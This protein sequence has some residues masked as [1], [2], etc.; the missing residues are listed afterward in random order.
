MCAGI[1]PVHSTST[2]AGAITVVMLNSAPFGAQ[3]AILAV[4]LVKL[5]LERAAGEYRILGYQAD[6]IVVNEQAY[7]QAIVVSPELAPEV[8]PVNSVTDMDTAHFE[9]LLARK[10]EVVL[11]GTGRR[12]VFPDMSLLASMYE[13]SIGI[14]IMDTAA[15]C[16]TFNII[17]GEGRRVVAGLLPLE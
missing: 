3:P 5:H 10:P 17:A 6:G 7:T 8:W 15:A 11:I 14:E 13:R 2:I 4:R 9:A 12:Q 1:A 16:R